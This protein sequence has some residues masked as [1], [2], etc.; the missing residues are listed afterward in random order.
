MKSRN[1][2]MK[3]PPII[4]GILASFFTCIIISLFYKSNQDYKY[5]QA[6][7]LYNNGNYEE[8][9]KQFDDL[10]FYSNS[11]DL[12][13]KA[14]F[15][16]EYEKAIDYLGLGENLNEN[17]DYKE[18]ARIFASLGDFEKS[19][20]Y[21]EIATFKYARQLFDNEQFDEASKLFLSIIDYVDEESGE[22]AETF[23]AKSMLP[24]VNDISET[25]YSSAYREY[26]EK[27]YINAYKDFSD[28]NGYEDSAEWME[29][30]RSKLAQE[31][32]GHTLSAGVRY[33]IAINND[34]EIK[35][36][37]DISSK[38]KDFLLNINN[39][40]DIKSISGFSSAVA[41]LMENGK[42]YAS[43]DSELD[44]DYINSWS[45][46]IAIAAG[47]QYIVGLDKD[48]NIFGEG[49]SND[50]QIDFQGWGKIVSFDTS[51]RRTVGVDIDGNIYITGYGSKHHKNEIDDANLKAQ[52]TNDEKIRKMAWNNIISIA[53]GGGYGKEQGHTV[54][55]KSDGTVVAVGDN[56]HNQLEVSEWEQVI[57]IAAGDYHT[58]GLTSNGRVLYAGDRNDEYID[59]DGYVKNW[60][61]IV[62]IAAGKDYT[63]ALTSEGDVLSFGD[64][65]QN[66][67]P[68]PREW[69]NIII[70]EWGELK[71]LLEQPIS[72]Q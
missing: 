39:K 56:N 71:E 8:A 66:Q 14:S 63:L 60:N 12:S 34:Y 28:L 32:L 20:Y 61:N 48:G 31:S 57:S 1:Y 15:Y 29:M 38:N 4:I 67:R 65:K 70:Y 22:D 50:G 42:V 72:H 53:T 58:V 41:V 5:N 45:D 30:C 16:M 44:T 6:K 10:G 36:T 19:K 21:W 13:V 18:A 9:I 24:A 59:Q 64:D 33:S 46:I 27:D 54:G 52:N 47:D 23:Y 55:L 26:N 62:A 2:K 68:K 35:Y 3:I 51:W 49:H 40:K 69:D 37:G 17:Q 25:V 7:V 11:L 43:S